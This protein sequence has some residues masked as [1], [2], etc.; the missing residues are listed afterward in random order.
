M[1]NNEHNENKKMDRREFMV[2]SVVLGLLG[3]IISVGTG[4]VYKFLK[5][6]VSYQ[7]P[8]KFR[9]NI[10]DLPQVGEELI[11]QEQKTIVRRKS[12][13]EVAAISLVCTHLGCIVNRVATGFLCPCHG[14]QYDNEGLVVG[15]P[16]PKTLSWHF[17][18]VI[19]GNQIEIDTGTS[20]EENTYFK[21]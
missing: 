20:L 2:N 8:K 18:K 10:K 21:I 4:A 15:G 6:V 12:L 11:Y 17:I 5:P 16:A 1:E 3:V 14:S 9:L 19:P 13:S 7:N